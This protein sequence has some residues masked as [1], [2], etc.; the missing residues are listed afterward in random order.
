[1]TGG[2]QARHPRVVGDPAQPLGARFAPRFLHFGGFRWKPPSRPPQTR[3]IQPTGPA[4]MAI[5]ATL[6]T[7]L[8]M[9]LLFFGVL[10]FSVTTAVVALLADY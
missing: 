10:L 3:A 2:L 4:P 5:L 9:A 8:P 1:M 6:G 7:S